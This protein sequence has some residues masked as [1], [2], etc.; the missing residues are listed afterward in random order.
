M[1]G[2][3]YG[4]KEVREQ[5]DASDRTGA[6]GWLLWNAQCVYTPGVFAGSSSTP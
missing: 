5:I 4:V 1:G 6:T 3:P 2:I